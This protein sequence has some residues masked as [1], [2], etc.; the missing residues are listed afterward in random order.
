L[1][2]RAKNRVAEP[3]ALAV[4]PA[5]EA[6]MSELT[7]KRPDGSRIFDSRLLSGHASLGLGVNF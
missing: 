6:W 2:R 5:G 1:G 7:A 3:C 4:R